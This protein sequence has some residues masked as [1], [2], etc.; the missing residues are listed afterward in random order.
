MFV[1]C[2]RKRIGTSDSR[3]GYRHYYSKKVCE[4]RL[5]LLLFDINILVLLK[6]VALLIVVLVVVVVIE[7]FIFNS[8]DISE[9]KSTGG[10]V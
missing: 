4:K 1:V 6:V 10:S 9:I 3:G 2:F 7:L 8:S 5:K